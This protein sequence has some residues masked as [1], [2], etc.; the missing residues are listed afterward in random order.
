MKR[1]LLLAG[2]LLGLLIIPATA[3]ATLRLNGCTAAAYRPTFSYAYGGLFYVRY[4]I[5]VNCYQPQTVDLEWQVQQQFGSNWVPVRGS[6]NGTGGW[7]IS[8]STIEWDGGFCCV[9]G[10][11]QFR[12]YIYHFTVGGASGAVA[13]DSLG[14]ASNPAWP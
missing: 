2:L 11:A 7:Y 12:T 4:P 10:D 14:G 13:I 1:V 3:S 9:P 6:S 8:N 5:S